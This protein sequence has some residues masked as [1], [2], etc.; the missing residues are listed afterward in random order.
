M[1]Y[2]ELSGLRQT[3]ADHRAVDDV[4]LAIERGELVAILGPSGSGKTTLLRIVGGFVRPT[5]GRVVLD[6]V[7]VT[8]RPP[9]QRRM[10]MVF[11]AYA[12][13]PNLSAGENVAFG[14]RV[15]RRPRSEIAARVRELLEMVD[16]GEKADR[17]PHQ[18]SGGEQQ[19]VALARALAPSPQVLLLDEPLSALDARIR[20]FLR[21]EIRRI[22]RQLGITTVYVTHD[23]EEALAMADK[24]VVMNR[25]RVEQVGSP[26]EI[27][28]RP[29]TAFVAA[30]VGAM[31][32]LEAR[33]QDPA[34]GLLT[35]DGQTLETAHMPAGL[36]A[37]ATVQV[38]LRPERITAAAA[39]GGNH[40]TGT[41]DEVGFLGATV[42]VRLR[43]RD[44]ACSMDMV[45][46]PERE[47]P[48]PGERLEVA[49]PPTALQT[50][51]GGEAAVPPVSVL[52]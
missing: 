8:Q 18:L 30:F 1:S 28:G 35:I 46:D 52:G 24:V 48:R 42:R 10:G 3:Y 19:R 15:A 36:A 20:L 4:D 50:L 2:L 34:R 37:G 13:F 44:Q 6:G 9:Q 39:G 11:Q 29:R 27:Y 23:Q 45:Y 49:V 47:L 25:G 14:L 33:V 38:L 31:N 26:A 41:V 12:L 16:L 5:A 43:L 21:Q 40:L 17:Y 32:R 51:G 7:D 22:Q